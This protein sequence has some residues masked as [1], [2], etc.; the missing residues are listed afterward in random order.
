MRAIGIKQIDATYR[1][2]GID[3]CLCLKTIQC[4]KFP[5]CG[6]NDPRGIA[7]LSAPQ[8]GSRCSHQ[9]G[10]ASGHRLHLDDWAKP[11]QLA[12]TNLKAL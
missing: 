11:P 4:G 10:E 8:T 12:A 1:S 9:E 3:T 6:V 2:D 7:P 5:V